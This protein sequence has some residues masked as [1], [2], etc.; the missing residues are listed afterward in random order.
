MKI[1]RNIITVYTPV[2]KNYIDRAVEVSI[3]NEYSDVAFRTVSIVN[4]SY[5]G[6][7]Q[8]SNASVSCI[9]FVLLTLEKQ[10]FYFIKHFAHNA[11]FRLFNYQANVLVVSINLFL[12]CSVN[13]NYNHNPTLILRFY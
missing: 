7:A 3:V 8:T 11:T 5:R 6:V 2:N 13:P 9:Y 12:G 10:W 4:D 1:Y